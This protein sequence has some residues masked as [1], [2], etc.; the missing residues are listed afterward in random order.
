[1]DGF[2]LLSGEQTDLAF[3]ELKGAMNALGDERAVERRSEKVVLL[4]EGAPEGLAERSALCHFTGDLYS[5]SSEDLGDIL[6]AVRNMLESLPVDIAVTLKVKAAGADGGPAASQLFDGAVAL[7][8]DL[9]IKVRHRSPDREMFLV[10]DGGTSYIG[11]ITGRSAR[12][13]LRGRSGSKLPFNRPIVMD[14]VLARAMVNITGLPPGRRVLDPFLGPGGLAIEAAKL[15]L[16]VIGIERD[17][18]IFQGAR[19]NFEHHGLSGYVSAYS[20]DS[21]KMDG[22]IG[23]GELRD[24][25]GIITDPPFGRSAATM[26]EKADSLLKEVIAKAGGYLKKGS[27]LVLDSPE[28]SVLEEIPGFRMENMIPIRVHRSMTRHVA[29]MLKL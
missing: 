12:K 6:R 27:P 3:L 7:M 4:K 9:G 14:P 1:M 2:A 8:K 13:E 19:S 26:G 29:L 24:I 10:L 17:P 25:D 21:R 5:M 22:L 28:S 16:H 18:V 20:G 23:A 15:G 11:W